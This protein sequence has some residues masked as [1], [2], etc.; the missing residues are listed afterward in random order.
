MDLQ[1]THKIFL[2]P[3]KNK[4]KN[5]EDT[6]GAKVEKCN[7]QKLQQ[8]QQQNLIQETKHLNS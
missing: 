4:M 7:V 8:Q 6:S 1:I 2:S 5:T 3:L